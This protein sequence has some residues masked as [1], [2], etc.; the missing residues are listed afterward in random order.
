MLAQE[1]TSVIE[2]RVQDQIATFLA[3]KSKLVSLQG[4][5]DFVL[6][7]KAK[8]LYAT[9]LQ[10]EAD[11]KDVLLRIDNIKSGAFALADVARIGTF[12]VSMENQIHQ[13]NG[14]A[15]QAGPLTSTPIVMVGMLGIALA[16]AYFWR[17]R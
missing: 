9:Q 2:A 6:R 5:P 4:A 3:L 13:V 11:L 10:L 17:T 14:L 8:A 16:L 12:A 7:D 1:F 15:K